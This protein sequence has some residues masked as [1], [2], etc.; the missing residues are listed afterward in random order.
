MLCPRSEI[1]K[2]SMNL[3][4]VFRKTALTVWA[5]E[6]VNPDSIVVSDSL[7][8]FR[9]IADAG[10]EHQAMVTGSRTAC[11]ELPERK[12]VNTTLGN[13]KTAMKGTQYKACPQHLPRQLV[14]FFYRFNC[15]FDLAAMLPRLV[16]AALRTLP[17]P[18]RR[19]KLA[20]ARW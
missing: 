13:V 2:L 18:Y 10:I 5:T 11:V 3:V 17:M 16:V 14:E 15:R 7:A 6:V 19:L 1:R 9:G 4:E 8:C 20:D 12:W